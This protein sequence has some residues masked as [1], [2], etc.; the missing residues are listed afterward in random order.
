MA[1]VDRVLEEIGAGEVPR[2]IVLNKVD[3]TAIE[4]GTRLDAYGRIVGLALSAVTGAGVDLLRQWLRERAADSGPLVV[5]G[6]PVTSHSTLQ[7]PDPAADLRLS[8]DDPGE[9][10]AG[11]AVPDTERSDSSQAAPAGGQSSAEVDR[12][13]GPQSSNSSTS[14]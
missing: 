1:A 6:L 4:P 8:G 7:S 3:R 9:N 14:A 11:A 12:S 10:P 13:A 5:D 2:L